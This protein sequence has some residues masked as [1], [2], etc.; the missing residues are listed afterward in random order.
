MEANKLLVSVP[1]FLDRELNINH[2]IMAELSRGI[3]NRGL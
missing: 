1:H 2:A 3:K